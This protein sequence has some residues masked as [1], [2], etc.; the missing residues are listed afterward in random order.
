MALSPG[1][2]CPARSAAALL[3]ICLSVVKAWVGEASVVLH[4]DLH[5]GLKQPQQLRRA[6]VLKVCRCDSTNLPKGTKVPHPN[7]QFRCESPWNLLESPKFIRGWCNLILLSC[8]QW[9]NTLS[10]WFLRVQKHGSFRMRRSS[11]QDSLTEKSKRIL[12][13]VSAN[14]TAELGVWH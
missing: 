14:Q 7:R 6:R 2:P 10:E 9:W 13:A 12:H 8:A 3:P 1:P 4:L 5:V 11:L